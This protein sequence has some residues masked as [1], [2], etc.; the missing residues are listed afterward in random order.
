MV[1]ILIETAISPNAIW[2]RFA[3]DFEP[4]KAE[5]WIERNSEFIEL[6]CL[7]LARTQ[8]GCGDLLAV[9]I[10]PL[11]PTE[12]KPNWEVLGFAPGLSPHA[13]EGAMKAID[14]L[15]EIYTLER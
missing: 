9:R 3:D 2:M 13:K 12:N 5:Y 4:E 11:K 15:R 8:H 14:V 6:A 10:C 7:R 1:F